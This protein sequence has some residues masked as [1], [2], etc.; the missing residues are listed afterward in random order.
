[1][2][3]RDGLVDIVLD[4]KIILK[5]ILNWDRGAWSRLMIGTVDGRF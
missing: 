3:D 5:W 2:R 1:M 4:W